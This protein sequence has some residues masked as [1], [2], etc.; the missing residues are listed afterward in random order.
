M[1]LFLFKNSDVSVLT[2]INLIGFGGGGGGGEMND[3]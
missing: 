1:V 2:A 3:N